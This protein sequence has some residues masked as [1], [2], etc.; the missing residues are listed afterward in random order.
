M[1]GGGG[2]AACTAQ[3][4]AAKTAAAKMPDGDRDFICE[5]DSEPE[6]SGR[7]VLPDQIACP[8]AP[9]SG[10]CSG[11]GPLGERAAS[12]C[13][14]GRGERERPPWA[15]AGPGHLLSARWG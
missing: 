11:S 13:R 5:T 1:G 15:A 3:A 14:P 2:E 8:V 12:G 7:K 9:R 6:G 10:S 4:S